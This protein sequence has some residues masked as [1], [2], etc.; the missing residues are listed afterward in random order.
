MKTSKTDLHQRH[1]GKAGLAL[2][3][4]HLARLGYDFTATTDNSIAGD[5]WADLGSGPE[6]VEVKATTRPA[7][8]LRRSQAARTN[9]YALVNIVDGDA[10]LV[11]APALEARWAGA[12][13]NALTIVGREL[14]SLAHI[15]LHHQ[16][17]KIV[18][19]LPQKKQREPRVPIPGRVR[20]VSKRLADGTVK[21]YEYPY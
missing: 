16:A 9:W 3:S 19:A 14:P 7:W 17:P 2:V 18:P 20:Q 11:A 5:I 12:G 10:W 15:A 21:V 1:I 8:T 13:C 4:F 6:V